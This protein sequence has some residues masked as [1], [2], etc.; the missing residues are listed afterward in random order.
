M[1]IMLTKLTRISIHANANHVFY[2]LR[3]GVHQVRNGVQRGYVLKNKQ[4]AGPT[5]GVVYLEIDVIFNTV[6][7]PMLLP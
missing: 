4:L 2:V 6:S 5:K 7:L 1:L 3:G